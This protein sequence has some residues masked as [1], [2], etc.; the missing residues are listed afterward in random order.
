VKELKYCKI[1]YFTN[2]ANETKTTKLSKSAKNENDTVFILYACFSQHAT[3]SERGSI[4]QASHTV[5]QRETSQNHNKEQHAYKPVNVT[6]D[7]TCS[8]N[9]NLGNSSQFLS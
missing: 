1:N 9:T 6:T 5:K 3:S 7:H 8:S 4:L 2:I